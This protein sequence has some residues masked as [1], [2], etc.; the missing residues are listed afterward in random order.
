[1]GKSRG[2]R[3]VIFSSSGAIPTI[4]DLLRPRAT[5]ELRHLGEELRGGSRER[6]LVIGEA[7]LNNVDEVE[8][9]D[10]AT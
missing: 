3:R 4:H 8:A 10:G 9:G 1:M 5:I 7:G 6:V 2:E